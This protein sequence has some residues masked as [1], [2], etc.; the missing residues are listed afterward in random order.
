[1]CGD[2]EVHRS[3]PVVGTAEIEIAASPAAV[4]EV[5]ADI[6]SWPSWNPDVKTMALSGEVAPGSQFRWKAGGVTIESAL[7]AVDPPRLIGWTGRTIGLKARHVYRFEPRDE[8]TFVSTEEPYDG[9][10]ARLFRKPIQRMLDKA[11]E[12][13]LGYL[14]AE[15]ERRA[16]T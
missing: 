10:A 1:V 4:W 8:G 15:A 14:K 16:S 11:L 2:V 3:A 12:D 5:L 9:W 7:E 6:E 13:G